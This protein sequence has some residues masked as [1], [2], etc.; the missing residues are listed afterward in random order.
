MTKLSFNAVIHAERLA[1][2]RI[3]ITVDLNGKSYEIGHVIDE[4]EDSIVQPERCL[5]CTNINNLGA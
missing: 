2:D 5:D 4:A 3:R 1:D